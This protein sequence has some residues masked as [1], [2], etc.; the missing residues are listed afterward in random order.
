MMMSARRTVLVFFSLSLLAATA[1]GTPP[2]ERFTLAR[3]AAADKDL[4]K[5]A[6]F[7]TR[8]S[9]G[10]LRDMKR[11]ADR[12]K[13]PYLKDPF[14]VLPEGDLEEVTLEGNAAVLKVKGK[15]K[16]VEVRMYMENDEWSIDLYSLPG[17]WAP[18]K[19]G[20]Q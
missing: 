17:L 9:A 11:A 6:G 1:C 7:F 8:Q 15:K 19:G 16:A 10:L 2:E 4:E 3:A 20:S 18:L 14:S 13:I 5:F 12:S